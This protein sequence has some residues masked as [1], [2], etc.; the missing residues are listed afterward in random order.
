MQT[1]DDVLL[2]IFGYS[3]FRA[4]QDEA[5]NATMQGRDVLAVMPTGGGKSMVYQVP[6]I[7]LG[8]TTLVLSPLI[9]LMKDQVERLQQR[10]IIADTIHGNR[11][12]GE[13]NNIMARAGR[14]ALAL[15]YVAPERLEQR[16]FRRMLAD[17]PISRV[18][19]D[20]AHCISEWGHDF[21]PSYMA[22]PSMFED[23]RRVPIIA[24][25][26]TATPEVRDDI[27]RALALQSPTIIV[28]GFDRPNLTFHVVETADKLGY[29]QQTLLNT[30][31]PTVVYCGSRKRVESTSAALVQRGL[32]CTAYHAGMDD[33][34][35]SQAQEQFLK[36]EATVLV[37]TS[38]FGMGVDKADVR[39]VLHM[40]LPPTLE[41]YYQEAG[42]AGRDG[43]AATCTL[44]YSPDD[45]KLVEFFIDMTFPADDI[46][47]SVLAHLFSQAHMP[48]GAH[49]GSYVWADAP[50][51][52]ASIARPESA[53]RGAL[54]VLEREGILSISRGQH[55]TTVQRTTSSER[56]NEWAAGYR[57]PSQDAVAALSRFIA[58]L[59]STFE[60]ELDMERLASHVS[61]GPAEIHRV[62]EMMKLAHLVAVTQ[63]SASSI[64]RLLVDR[65]ALAMDFLPT[66][67]LRRERALRKLDV[68]DRFATT[69]TCKRSFILAYFGEEHSSPCGRCSSCKPA[70]RQQ[71]ADPSLI[72][73]IKALIR[74]VAEAGER[75]GRTMISDIAAGTATERIVQNELHRATTFGILFEVPAPERQ[76]AMDV[77]VACGYLS[78]TAS[79]YPT[80]SLTPQARSLVPDLPRPLQRSLPVHRSAPRSL[81]V[82]LIAAR[83]SWARSA[84]VEPGNILPLT[85]L[86]RIAIDVPRDI[87]DLRPG[88]H[89]SAA[90]LERFGREL[91]NVIN[92]WHG[93]PPQQSL[94]SKNTSADAHSFERLLQAV[95]P[96]RSLRHVAVVLGM[97]PAKVAALVQEAVEEGLIHDKGALVPDDLFDAVLQ[98]LRTDQSVTIRDVQHRLGQPSDPAS[99]R[100]AMAFA[101]RILRSA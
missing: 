5:I 47:T 24:V 93:D 97:V 76:R 57:G 37:A 30:S 54:A 45:R 8:G 92:S 67:A 10:G 71:T 60:R 91:V 52:A 51:I 35:R 68:V 100:V 62:L 33:R 49:S 48:G 21:R 31:Q 73:H 26:A 56:I 13:I 101:R 53:V 18:A 58:S 61:V 79:T 36:G 95:S 41:A 87:A 22:I 70:S 80:L 15:L 64:I 72:P 1:A 66:I 46:I 82:A 77:A 74:V 94:R 50:S 17:V 85:A 65:T 96:E 44:L 89:G 23:I 78:L 3:S 2:N 20:E 27:C 42:R 40:D 25:T 88:R 84:R 32:A 34:Q 9:A 90:F 6:A 98:I 14:G 83:T 99:V 12:L 81:M 63:P 59:P 69:A 39:E 29:V 28:K 86:E 38:A 11:S 55:S 16:S 4:G 75:Y 43:H 19:I 7:A